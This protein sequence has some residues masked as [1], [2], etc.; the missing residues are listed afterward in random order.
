MQS[1]RIEDPSEKRCIDPIA[2]VSAAVIM[3]RST[4]RQTIYTHLQSYDP[5]L[6]S[7]DTFTH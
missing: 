5:S 4:A 2:L 3:P 7:F 1:E 6:G